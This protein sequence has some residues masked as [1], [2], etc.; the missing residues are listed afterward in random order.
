MPAPLYILDKKLKT[1]TFRQ[2]EI[3]KLPVKH[4]LQ[5]H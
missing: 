4:F 5:N 3:K 1:S 2:D